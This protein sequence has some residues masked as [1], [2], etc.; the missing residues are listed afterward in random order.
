[1]FVRTIFTHEERHTYVDPDYAYTDEEAEA[2]QA[3][4]Q[5]YK[6]Y[7]D[8]LRDMRRYKEQVRYLS[9]LIII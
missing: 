7:I 9:L 6:D 4:K 1:M 2:I 8:Y 5:Y 3:H